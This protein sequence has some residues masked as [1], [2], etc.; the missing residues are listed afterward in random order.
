M[1][2]RSGP[3]LGTRCGGSAIAVFPG[4]AWISASLPQAVTAA[5]RRGVSR[6]FRIWVAA[7]EDSE[8]R[9]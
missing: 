2:P 6:V 8:L 4:T 3:G 9:A 1:A 5:G 7:A